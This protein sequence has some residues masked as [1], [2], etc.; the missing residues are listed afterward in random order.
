M[1]DEAIDARRHPFARTVQRGVESQWLGQICLLAGGGE[2]HDRAVE[3][4][5][6]GAVSLHVVGVGGRYDLADGH[7]ADRFQIQI[8]WGIQ[9]FAVQTFSACT[10]MNLVQP[11]PFQFSSGRKDHGIVAGPA[12]TAAYRLG[13]TLICANGKRGLNR[14]A[15][16][17][18][19]K[20]N[21]DSP[22]QAGLFAGQRAAVDD[23]GGPI[24]DSAFSNI[25][26]S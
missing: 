19:V 13:I 22:I 7:K 4:D 16:H 9:V 12:E 24:Y 14:S 8:D 3:Q 6:N 11:L 20:A 5:G 1:R 25:L 2:R 21:S 10:D 18:L 26:R 17:R 15:I 23:L